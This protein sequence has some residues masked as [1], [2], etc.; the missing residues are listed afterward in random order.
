MH[1]F[2]YNCCDTIHF[3]SSALLVL[4]KL[5]KNLLLA[6]LSP[7]K[8]TICGVEYGRGRLN[9][10]PEL[11]VTLRLSTTHSFSLAKISLC[12]A[13]RLLQYFT[14]STREH[15]GVFGLYDKDY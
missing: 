8:V 2:R 3:V 4:C 7:C 5:R 10:K 12:L 14:A 15:D 11:S 13:R 1:E 9:P 6:R